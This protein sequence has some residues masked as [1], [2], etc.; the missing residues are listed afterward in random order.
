MAIFTSWRLS[1]KVIS[2]LVIFVMTPH[3]KHT[4]LPVHISTLSSPH[5]H[6]TGLGRYRSS[7]VIVREGRR[8][9]GSAAIGS[10]WACELQQTD[11]QGGAGS[12]T[13]LAGLSFPPRT[14]QALSKSY[15]LWWGF[16]KKLFQLWSCYEEDYCNRDCITTLPALILGWY[17]VFTGW[18]EYTVDIIWIWWKRLMT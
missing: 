12:L 4:W 8:G 18:E 6:S 5:H 15:W 16:N 1:A 13:L 10:T 3:P 17:N 7:V 9:G 14:D 11:R 2:Y